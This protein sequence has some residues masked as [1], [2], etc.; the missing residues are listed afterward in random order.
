MLEFFLITLNFF[1]PNTTKLFSQKIVLE[2]LYTV[3]VYTS[4]QYSP[5]GCVAATRA[6]II[7]NATKSKLASE[8]A[9]LTVKR[10]R[11]LGSIRVEA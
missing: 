7:P 2:I 5:V 8:M 1:S 10:Q 6:S 9:I 3:I 4:V 11:S